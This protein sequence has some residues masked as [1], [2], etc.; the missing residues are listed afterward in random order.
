MPIFMFRDFR[1]GKKTI[2]VKK[3]IVITYPFR[4]LHLAQSKKSHKSDLSSDLW[5][6]QFVYRLD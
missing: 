3:T 6:F 1:K 5:D 2:I 4:H